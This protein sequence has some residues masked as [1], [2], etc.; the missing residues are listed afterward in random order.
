MFSVMTNSVLAVPVMSFPS[1][2]SLISVVIDAVP[3]GITVPMVGGGTMLP[4]ATRKS[5]LL[6][7]VLV[8]SLVIRMPTVWIIAQMG[9]AVLTA[10]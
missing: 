5:C 6:V 8:F 3:M 1:V 4:M 7:T 9:S 2:V 10:Q